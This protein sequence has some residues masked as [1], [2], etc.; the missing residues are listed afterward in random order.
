MIAM[1]WVDWSIVVI[2]GASTVISLVRGFLKEAVSL[3]VWVLALWIAFRFSGSL[4]MVLV[5]YVKTPSVRLTLSFVILLAVTLILGGFI[6][7]LLSKIV[8]ETGLGVMDKILGVAFGFGRGVLLIA[9]LL[10]VASMT[11]FSNEKFWNYSS[12]VPHFKPVVLWLRTFLP[13]QVKHISYL[14]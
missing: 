1:T 14:I 3:L 2:I 5:S 8:V 10:L 6:N 9:V 11:S 13:E 7:F 12:L 4:S